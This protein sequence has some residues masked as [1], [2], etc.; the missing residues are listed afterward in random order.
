MTKIYT[1]TGDDGTTSAGFNRRVSKS[2]P[3]IEAIGTIDELNAAIGVTMCYLEP[4]DE[5]YK[6]FDRIQKELFLLGESILSHENKITEKHIT[7][8]EKEIDETKTSLDNFVMPRGNLFQAHCHLARTICRRA[9]RKTTNLIK[10]LKKG[11][12]P[13]YLNRLS[14]WLF[15]MPLTS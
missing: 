4:S 14:D 1:K 10:D 8:L 7:L 6:K 5:K 13:S 3:L 11:T 12:V 9:E 2:D 15:V